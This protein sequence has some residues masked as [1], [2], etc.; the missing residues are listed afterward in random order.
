LARNSLD[1]GRIIYLIDEGKLATLQFSTFWFD[2]TPQGKLMLAIAFGMSKYYVDNLSENI[3]RGQERKVKDGIFP[4]W[5]P[6][7][8]LNDTLTR[9]ITIDPHRGPLIR[10]A[11]ELYATGTHTLRDVRE[12]INALGLIGKKGMELSVSNYQYLLRNPVYFGLIRY[13]GELY[14]GKHEPLVGKQLFDRCQEVMSRKSQ[15]KKPGFKPYLYR[16]MFRCGECGCFIT[17]E[18]KT[19]RH[20]N[21][22]VHHYTY[23]RCTKRVK[24][25]SQPCVREEQVSSQITAALSAV[26][27]PTDWTNWMLAELE[28]EQRQDTQ[29]T[30]S[31]ISSF[32][33]RIREID[34]KLERLLDAYTNQVLTLDEFREAKGKLIAEKQG[35]KEKKTAVEANRVSRLEPVIGFVKALEKASVE[36]ETRTEIENRDFLKKVGSNLLLKDGEVSWMPR[37]AWQTL[38]DHGPFAR[39]NVAHDACAPICSGETDHIYKKRREWDSNPR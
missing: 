38:I 28:A 13:S 29:A 23:C 2:P 18:A 21:G 6:L 25:C 31:D 30:V 4:Q 8:Y 15:P 37:D 34:Q 1:G 10:K 36:K 27:V 20:K 7:G 3:K 16:G 12:K 26:A 9:T 35:I 11:F 5:A 32:Q 19:K 17:T 24:P 33:S 14:E 39:P 22:N